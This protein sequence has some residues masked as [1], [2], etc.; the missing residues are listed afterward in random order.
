MSDDIFEKQ[1]ALKEKVLEDK[2]QIDHNLKKLDLLEKS[3]HR[4]IERMTLE[5]KKY[6]DWAKYFG[7]D[8]SKEVLMWYEE[9]LKNL[10]KKMGRVQAMREKMLSIQNKVVQEAAEINSEFEKLRERAYN[11]SAKH[12][13]TAE[14]PKVAA[15]KSSEAEIKPDGAPDSSKQP[16]PSSEVA[17]KSIPVHAKPEIVPQKIDRPQKEAIK[18]AS[19]S[20]ASKS[21]VGK[22]M[23]DFGQANFKKAR[24]SSPV[25]QKTRVD[26]SNLKPQDV[27]RKPIENKVGNPPEPKLPLPET[28][29]SKLPTQKP[30][31]KGASTIE[32]NSSQGRHSHEPVRIY[33]QNQ[34]TPPQKEI[35]IPS[36]EIK[37]NNI[38]Q[39]EEPP[40][41][42]RAIQT[43]IPQPETI[44]REP[45][46]PIS[47]VRVPVAKK[48]V[49]EPVKSDP[50]VA[51]VVRY[52]GESKKIEAQR[53]SRAK[54]HYI[55]KQ[56]VTDETQ[57]AVSDQIARRNVPQKASSILYLGID[58]G[59]CQT[60]VCSNAGHEFTFKSAIGWPKDLVS[61]KL[62]QKEVLYGD[63]ALKHKLSLR[64]YRPFEYGVIKDTDEDLEAAREIIKYALSQV[65]TERYDKTYAIIGAPSQVTL[66]NE[67]A[68]YDAARQIVDAVS[69]VSEPFAVAYGE[70][71]IYN[72]MV[73][74]IGAGTT[75]ICC[76]KGTLPHK[77]D[78][79]STTK[80]GDYI[81]LRLQE[82]ICNRI[83]GAQ[84]TKDLAQKWK[85][86]F[87]FVGA[88]D[89]RAIIEITVMGKPLKA[90]ITDLIG[91][92]CE[93]ITDDIVKACMKLISSYDP[94]FQ[95][96][97]KENIVLAGGGSLIGNLAGYL[98]QQLRL[99]G[100]V[101]IKCVKNPFVAGA[102]GALALAQDVSDDFWRGL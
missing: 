90:D 62:L 39:P 89:K 86:A 24:N 85:E 73:I 15:K 50:G 67:Q 63:E 49:P 1:I 17:P 48:P 34:A 95:N 7:D 25:P 56:P 46:K 12:D 92:S 9:E 23:P 57:K 47:E 55:A 81:D 27:I 8:R 28:L 11:I 64:L 74:D 18:T 43:E 10:E 19:P 78:Q 35:D 13:K 61:R 101:N 16:A 33:A 42:K 100:N 99:L 66:R 76:L 2:K 88:P 83:R 31:G 22:N 5:K 53:I 21:P 82:M 4:E 14:P 65:K 36:I 20:N 68:I 97:L 72:T 79:V 87:S 40:Q 30:N 102:R 60:T 93:S 6:G 3:V 91:K 45:E 44:R 54:Q 29:A 41:M 70:H 98:T 51:K 59:T 77:G 38:V 80:A 26:I 71:N 75:D 58:L 32:S 69:I 84:V 37:K 96:N 94:E 52:P